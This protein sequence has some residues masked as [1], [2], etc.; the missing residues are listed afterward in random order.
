MPIISSKANAAFSML[1]GLNTLQT[2]IDPFYSEYGKLYNLCRKMQSV[3]S[4]RMIV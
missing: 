2:L 4:H 1:A 3:A